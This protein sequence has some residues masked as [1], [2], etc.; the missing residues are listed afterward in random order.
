MPNCPKCQ[1]PLVENAKFCTHCGALIEAEPLLCPVCYSEI[2]AGSKFCTSC[3]TPVGAVPV[4]QIAAPSP[5]EATAYAVPAK[6]KGKGGLIAAIIALVLVVVLGVSWVLGAFD[7]LFEE[8]D[9]RTDSSSRHDK[10]DEEEEEEAEENGDVTAPP[11][12]DVEDVTAPSAE[13]YDGLYRVA[14]ITDYGDVTDQSYNQAIWE[15]VEDFGSLYGIPVTYYRPQTLDNTSR[16]AAVEMA[17]ANGYNVLVLSGY[18]FGSTIAEV[19]GDYPDVK[20]IA[21]D[22]TEGD[23]LEGGVWAAGEVY[24]YNPDNWELTDYVYMDNVYC[25][26]YQEEIAGF[27][28]GYAAVQMGY[29]KLGFVGGMA[30]PAILRYNY[31]FLQGADTAAQELGVEIEIRYAYANQYY[32][33][34]EITAYMESW[35][36]DGTEVIFACGG[37]LW[38]SVAEA[39]ANCGGKVIGLDVDQAYQIDYAYGE[40]LTITSAMK[41]LYPSTMDVLTDAL[42][43]GNWE[44]YAGEIRTLGLITDEDPAR[45]YVQLAPNTQFGVGNF[46]EEDYRKLVAYLYHG[47]YEIYVDISADPVTLPLANTYL[48]FWG[49]LK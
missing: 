39:A 2:P 13:D 28:A 8:D 16:V 25:I 12:E 30:V 37:G 5:V 18:S 19:S 31:G 1:R 32:G 24:D 15:A 11:A 17:I 44:D 20:F 46:G 42:I 41:G 33:D 38:T 34:A 26:N 22:L 27:M 14:M 3:G 21:L 4:S 6:K 7:G 43:Y 23:L 10:D 45:N 9:R 29:T 48:I 47:K 35:Y 40:G 36:D 49:Y